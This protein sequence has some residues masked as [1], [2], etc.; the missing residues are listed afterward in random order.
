MSCWPYFLGE[1]AARTSSDNLALAS[2]PGPFY[3]GTIRNRLRFGGKERMPMPKAAPHPDTEISHK[4]YS[5]GELRRTYGAD[6]NT[7]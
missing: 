3:A 4:K 1:G 2:T 5:I 7:R 6:F